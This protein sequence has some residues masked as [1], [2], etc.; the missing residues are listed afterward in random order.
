M[1]RLS[2]Q[3]LFLMLVIVSLM[4]GWW[5]D[6]QR[7]QKELE[8]QQSRNSIFAIDQ[9]TRRQEIDKLATEKENP[10]VSLLLLA[11]SD[12]DPIIR[13]KALF[14]LQDIPNSK[15]PNRDV[16]DTDEFRRWISESNPFDPQ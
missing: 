6:H 2:L 1:R 8:H 15:F 4:G 10:K 14:A 7:L 5:L 16:D 12:P 11:L 3:S 13:R 9:E